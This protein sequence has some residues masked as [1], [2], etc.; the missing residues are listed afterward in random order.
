VGGNG[1]PS[2]RVK[3]PPDYPSFG[4]HNGT[5]LPRVEYPP[6]GATFGADIALAVLDPGDLPDHRSGLGACATPVRIEPDALRAGM[7]SAAVV[8][9]PDPEGSHVPSIHVLAGAVVGDGAG[10]AALRR[11][12]GLAG[13]EASVPAA[14]GALASIHRALRQ[15]ASDGTR[16]LDF[17]GHVLVSDD[18]TSVLWPKTGR[19]P[20]LLDGAAVDR[21]LDAPLECRALFY[22]DRLLS[23]LAF[24]RMVRQFERIDRARERR[25]GGEVP[26]R[27]SPPVPSWTPEADDDAWE[28]AQH[29]GLRLQIRLVGTSAA[30]GLLARIRTFDGRDYT[31]WGRPRLGLPDDGTGTGTA[32]E[33]PARLALQ[34]TVDLATLERVLSELRGWRVRLAAARLR[35]GPT[36]DYLVLED[37]ADHGEGTV[38]RFFLPLSPPPSLRT[39]GGRAG[40]RA[41][42][43][44]GRR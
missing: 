26:P 9:R 27:L 8:A 5:P 42:R 38:I 32:A 34:G 33:P 31:S 17:P 29:D 18:S 36:P 2:L 20:H 41:G 44:A 22:R 30:P 3:Y 4:A 43:R 13:V 1:R 39:G 6:D 14:A 23:D 28:E 10:G 11:A 12:P 37:V 35:G 16:L 25:A 7:H 40:A 19:S 24:P 15:M 21:L